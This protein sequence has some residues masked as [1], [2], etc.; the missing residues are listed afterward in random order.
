MNDLISSLPEEVFEKMNELSTLLAKWNITLG[1][2]FVF[3]K[4]DDGGT[5]I[6]IA[7]NPMAMD[8]NQILRLLVK[9]AEKKLAEK[10]EN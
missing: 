3:Q 8:P 1:A 5:K 7:I 2:L 4:L 6:S 9:C 10:K